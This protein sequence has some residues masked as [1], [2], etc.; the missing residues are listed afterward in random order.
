MSD[1]L[2]KALLPKNDLEIPD[3]CSLDLV[4][5]AIWQTTNHSLWD[6]GIFDTRVK[7]QCRNFARL[8]DALYVAVASRHPTVRVNMRDFEPLNTSNDL[9]AAVNGNI[10]LYNDVFLAAVEDC[11]RTTENIFV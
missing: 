2:N 1:V 9:W 8:E 7:R 3:G 6:L 10:Y 11:Y 4:R 5:Q